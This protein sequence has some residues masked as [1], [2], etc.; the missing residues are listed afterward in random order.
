MAKEIKIFQLQKRVSGVEIAVGAFDDP[1]GD[2]ASD[3]GKEVFFGGGAVDQLIDGGGDD[4]PTETVAVA[5]SEPQEAVT[6]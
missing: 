6:V 5:D 1:A 4:T 2:L 3:P